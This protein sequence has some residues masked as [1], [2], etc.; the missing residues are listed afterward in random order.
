MGVPHRPE[1][2]QELANSFC[3]ND[4]EIAKHFAKHFAKLTFLSDHRADVPN[5]NTRSRKVE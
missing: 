5:S 2:G 3:R 1:L 4:P